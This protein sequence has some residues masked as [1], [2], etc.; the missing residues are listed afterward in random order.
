MEGGEGGRGGGGSG[1]GTERTKIQVEIFSE[2]YFWGIL[3]KFLRF[4]VW[5]KMGDVGY[6]KRSV[7]L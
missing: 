3:G 4:R 1:G 5:H 7:R 6:M 2:K